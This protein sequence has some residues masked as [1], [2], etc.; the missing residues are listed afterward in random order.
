MEL[1]PRSA[2]AISPLESAG[3]SI[4]IAIIGG[5]GVG[6]EL[7]TGGENTTGECHANAQEQ[8]DTTPSAILDNQIGHAGTSLIPGFLVAILLG[9]QTTRQ[10]IHILIK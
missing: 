10:F 5:I 3:L 2:L 1:N 4:T 6:V 7:I 8:H 9:V